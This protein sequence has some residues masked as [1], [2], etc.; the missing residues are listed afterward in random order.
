M[1][2]RFFVIEDQADLR[3]VLRD[4]LT[5]WGYAVREAADGEAG[6]AKAAR[7]HTDGHFNRAGLTA[8]RPRGKSRPTPI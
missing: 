6:V 1:T 3:G 7:S 5:G 8:T 4:L 2:K